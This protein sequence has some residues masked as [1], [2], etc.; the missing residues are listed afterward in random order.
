VRLAGARRFVEGLDAAE[1]S[2]RAA[3]AEALA[4]P[5]A[6]AEALIREGGP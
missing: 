1:A 4:V 5:R 2:L 6:A 3:A